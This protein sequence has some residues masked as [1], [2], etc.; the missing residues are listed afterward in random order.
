MVPTGTGNQGKPGEM[1]RH[2]PVR[3][4]SGNFVK[5]GKVRE[6]YSKYWENWKK[7]HWKIEKNTGKVR[8]ICQPVIVKTLQ[9]W[10]HT[11]NKKRTLKNTG[12]LQKIL[13]KSGKFVSPKK[14]EPCKRR[15]LCN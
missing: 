3:E 13:V 15:T 4:K 8:E 1:G 5:T 9:I 7:L 11:L 10:Y 6:F 14:W 12:K 2:F